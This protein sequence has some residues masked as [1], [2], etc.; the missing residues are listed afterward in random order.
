MLVSLIEIYLEF[1]EGL[2]ELRHH[3]LFTLCKLLGNLWG[4]NNW[5][6][7]ARQY[8]PEFNGYI[9]NEKNDVYCGNLWKGGN[10]ISYK[11]K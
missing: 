2:R 3:H 4:K 5:V 9:E 8:F 11:I 7:K 6:G 10:M 1:I